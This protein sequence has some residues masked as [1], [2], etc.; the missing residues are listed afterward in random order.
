MSDARPITNIT[1]F[2]CGSC[3][4]SFSKDDPGVMRGNQVVCPYCGNVLPGD[5]QEGDH[6]H[7]AV[8][9]APQTAL[10]DSD[11][12]PA[13]PAAP[14]EQAPGFPQ[15]EDPDYSWMPPE[16]APA[17][18]RQAGFVAG[19]SGTFDDD[20]GGATLRP[21]QSH[22]R[23]MELVRNAPAARQDESGDAWPGMGDPGFVAGDELPADV[24]ERTPL[25]LG[26]RVAE[27]LEGNEAGGLAD[28]AAPDLPHEESSELGEA[29]AMALRDWKLKA[30][31]LTY[32]FHGLDALLG[33]A[34][35]KAG[36]TMSVSND[37]TT[38]KD[39]GDF[40]DAVKAGAPV[41]RAFEQACEPGAPRQLDTASR[42][43][44]SSSAVKGVHA[45]D[46]QVSRAPAVEPAP[47]AVAAP[48]DLSPASHPSGRL[49]APTST[50][51]KSTT[52]SS[53]R[54]ATPAASTP[55]PSPMTPTR[56]AL[57]VIVFVVAVAIV[58]S[59]VL[60]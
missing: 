35:N 53:R 41:N 22:E 60:K 9:A 5:A 17:S 31:G 20:L 29:D 33:W 43:A 13:M 52:G 47:G 23:L 14:I 11:S 12:Y 1:G 51:A 34:A 6:L 58:L 57:A 26:S 45:P 10:R 7:S 19:D 28:D 50:M 24:D 37:G 49:T 18:P 48:V 3:W 55:A 54:I 38:W 59:Q 39:F 8:R 27:M 44:R 2:V 56:I 32:N 4:N 25:D 21:D 42:M 46:L 30:M 40:F 36:Q 15:L 16:P